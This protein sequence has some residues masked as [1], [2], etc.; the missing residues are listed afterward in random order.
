[1]VMN[2]PQPASPVRIRWRVETADGVQDLV[3]SPDGHWLAVAVVSGPLTVVDGATSNRTVLV[4]V[5]LGKP[6]S[7]L[8]G[9]V[10]VDEEPE[11]G[12]KVIG[13]P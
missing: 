1:M 13:A 8:G 5:E 3:W 4:N 10:Q 11:G 2:T 9:T 12:V 6:Y 7:L